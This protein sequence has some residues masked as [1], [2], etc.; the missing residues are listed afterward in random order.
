LSNQEPGRNAD[1]EDKSVGDKFVNS[2][3]PAGRAYGS[4]RGWFRSGAGA[5]LLG[6]GLYVAVQYWGQKATDP[7][8]Y[9]NL[10]G[11][12]KVSEG[13][14]DEGIELLNRAIERSPNWYQ[15]YMH[16]GSAYRHKG[17][18]DRALADLDKAISLNPNHSEAYYERA[19]VWRAKHGDPMAFA[20]LTE[21]IRLKPDYADAYHERALIEHEL[22]ALETAVADLDKALA[23]NKKSTWFLT[24]AQINFFELDRAGP[25]A[26]DF[27]AAAREAISYRD[28][29]D[30][31]SYAEPGGPKK[32]A[33]MSDTRT[34]FNTNGF[35]LL[36]W[37]HYARVHDGQD[38]AAERA[39]L[40][41]KL[42]LPVWKD[43]F[44]HDPMRLGPNLDA[45]AQARSLSAWPGAIYLMILGKS[46]PESV[47]QTAESASGETERVRRKCDVDFYLAVE[48]LGRRAADDARP[49]L[50]SAADGCPA[51]SMERAFAVYE[52]KRLG[53]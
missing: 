23:L 49:L 10:N 2:G 39:E 17:D 5:I 29:V 31:L 19:L 52:L 50:Q 21:A 40:A 44:I 38:D 15:P 34:P 36:L 26:D 37:A 1:R 14:Y 6:L 20:D 16:R 27:A 35:Y 3:T 11:S 46:T 32:Q 48:Q 33:P 7:H 25:A 45:E 42:A 51:Q 24:R 18:L 47:R 28:F 43:L 8:Q 22:G 53:S 13:N 12:L 4:V 41:E 30:L 9:D